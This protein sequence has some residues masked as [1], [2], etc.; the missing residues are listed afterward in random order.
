MNAKQIQNVKDDWKAQISDPKN[1]DWHTVNCFFHPD[2]P[3]C[4]H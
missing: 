3:V 2:D 1:Q 4:H